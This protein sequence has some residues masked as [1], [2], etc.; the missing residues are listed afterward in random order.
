MFASRQNATGMSEDFEAWHVLMS[1]MM[2]SL[3]I[4]FAELLYTVMGG[5]GEE[6]EIDDDEDNMELLH[7]RDILPPRLPDSEVPYNHGP[8]NEGDIDSEDDSPIGVPLP[9]RIFPNAA[10]PNRDEDEDEWEI[11]SPGQSRSRRIKIKGKLRSA[12]TSITI[13]LMYRQK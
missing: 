2:L 3:F 11:P 9:Q 12:T 10:A 13:G 4:P 1:G 8:E 5:E 7:P 6:M